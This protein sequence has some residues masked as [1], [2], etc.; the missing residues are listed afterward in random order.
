MKRYSDETI[1]IRRQHFDLLDKL[2]KQK[3]LSL[4]D[5]S[6]LCELIITK[7]PYTYKTHP[8]Y[9]LE[10]N[11][12]ARQTI[13]AYYT[14]KDTSVHIYK[15][16]LS[17]FSPESL[18]YILSVCGHECKHFYQT[19]NIK[20]YA[21]KIANYK[22]NADCLDKYYD[23][24][25]ALENS[26][27]A[28]FY[29]RH[30]NNAEQL[31][32]IVYDYTTPNILRNKTNMDKFVKKV[33]DGTYHTFLGEYDAML[34]GAYFT[35]GM[36]KSYISDP[37]IDEYPELK[38]SM[39]HQFNI[40]KGKFKKDIDKEIKDI[41]KSYNIANG[42]L[43][44]FLTNLHELALD[45]KIPNDDYTIA[46]LT[47][48]YLTLNFD[49]ISVTEAIMANLKTN[50]DLSNALYN[51]AK[52]KC[53][54]TE[55]TQMQS[56]IFDYAIN[57]QCYYPAQ[58]F[59][60]KQNSQLLDKMIEHKDYE[61]LHKVISNDNYIALVKPEQYALLSNI[62]T[63]DFNNNKINNIAPVYEVVND[64]FPFIDDEKKDKLDKAIREYYLTSVLDKSPT[65]QNG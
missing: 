64:I 60:K 6:M 8:G 39:E 1:E 15:K 7:N 35:Y 30:H 11:D 16:T 2:F 21:S 55:L 20:K 61:H 50:R 28:D 25:M 45:A 29:H 58:F 49:D 14:N 54:K 34:S 24:L 42:K 47:A 27:N 5:A 44:P 56:E 63:N 36:M 65:N 37:L 3:R 18:P 62:I 40:T 57:N 33:K 31:A 51:I 32:K 22:G 59:S 43:K 46:N 9:K 4:E 19:H 52:T 48:Y 13:K 53:S 10:E 17:Y 23:T 26:M 41:K 38:N 12:N